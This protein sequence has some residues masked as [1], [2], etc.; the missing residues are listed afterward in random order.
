MSDLMLI[1]RIHAW[2]DVLK[3]RLRSM[4]R[5]IDVYEKAMT[6]DYEEVR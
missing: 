5:D 1:S 2:H 3:N 4:R 6:A